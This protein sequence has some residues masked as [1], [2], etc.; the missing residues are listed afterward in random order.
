MKLSFCPT[1]RQ[2]K[3]PSYVKDEEYLEEFLL[4]WMR[5]TIDTTLQ[6]SNEPRVIAERDVGRNDQSINNL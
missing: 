5:Q 2:R 1:N 4:G 3:T 6:V